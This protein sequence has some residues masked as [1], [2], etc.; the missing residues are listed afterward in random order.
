MAIHLAKAICSSVRL[1]SNLLISFTSYSD[2]SF[3]PTTNPSSSFPPF[4]KG[5]NTL[6]PTIIIFITNTVNNVA[7]ING[8][9]SDNPLCNIAGG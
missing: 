5:I 3:N 8:Y 2:F 6:L 1:S 7:K 4:P 9:N